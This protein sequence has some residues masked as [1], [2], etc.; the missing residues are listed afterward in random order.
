[1]IRHR[2]CLRFQLIYFFT[3]RTYRD[4]ISREAAH[5]VRWWLRVQI[6][7]G[8]IIRRHTSSFNKN[9]ILMIQRWRLIRMSWLS[10]RLR[11]SDRRKSIKNFIIFYDFFSIEIIENIYLFFYQNVINMLMY[12]WK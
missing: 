2:F 7:D 10:E 1:M 6:T 11:K 9:A 12:Q 8:H 3:D 4:P 5:L